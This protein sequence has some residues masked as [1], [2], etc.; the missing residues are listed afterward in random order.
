VEE[1]ERMNL[2]EERKQWNQFVWGAARN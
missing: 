1:K 2:K